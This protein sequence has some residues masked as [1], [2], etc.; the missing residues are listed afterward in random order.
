MG[1]ILTDSSLMEFGT[2]AGEPV[3]TPKDFENKDGTFAQPMDCLPKGAARGGSQ[4][5]GGRLGK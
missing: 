5:G 2:G 4:V 3:I 1:D